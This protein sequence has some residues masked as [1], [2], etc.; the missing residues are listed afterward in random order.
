MEVVARGETST[1]EM[2]ICAERAMKRLTPALNLLADRVMVR[3][4]L[5]HEVAEQVEQSIPWMDRK[6]PHSIFVLD[7]ELSARSRPSGGQQ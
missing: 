5:L 6:P 4:T 7:A 2:Q 1:A 3:E